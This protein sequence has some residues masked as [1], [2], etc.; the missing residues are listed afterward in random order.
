MKQVDSSSTVPAVQKADA[1]SHLTSLTN[2]YIL[3]GILFSAVELKLFDLI[4]ESCVSASELAA[5]SG[6][7]STSGIERLLYALLNMGLV[8]VDP[9]KKFFLPETSKKFLV[10]TAETCIVPAIL[11]HYQ[12]SYIPFHKLSTAIRSGTPQPQGY[13]QSRANSELYETLA[14][15]VGEYE[16]FM[17]AMNL[18]SSGVGKRMAELASLSDALEIYDIGGGGAQVSLEL[19]EKLPN[20]RI[21]LLDRKEAIDYV[22]L[23]FRKDFVGRFRC[24]EGDMFAFDPQLPQADAVVLSA[25]LGDWDYEKR[26]QILKNSWAYLRPG[27]KLIISETLLYEDKSGPA[28][29]IFLSLYVLLLTQG[30][31]NFSESEWREFLKSQNISNI[32]IIRDSENGFRDLIICTKPIATDSFDLSNT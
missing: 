18:F 28:N 23:N 3:S 5:I 8:E 7:L 17:K 21:T 30:G 22:R 32:Q 10:T 16:I 4:N 12:H 26:C 2:G 11:H 24:L 20:S 14:S 1:L 15:R 9:D 31:G 29:A 27:G 13:E 19:L 25:V 6:C